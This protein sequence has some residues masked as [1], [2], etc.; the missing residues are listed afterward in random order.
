MT[1]LG[2]LLILNLPQ[3]LT[4]QTPVRWAFEN[5]R[6]SLGAAADTS[7]LRA[8]LENVQRRRAASGEAL[9]PALRAGLIGLRLG[10]LGADPGY[11]DALSRF[12]RAAKAEPGRPEPWFGL[13]LAEAGRSEWEMKNPLALGSRVGLGALERSV[14]N[15]A[16][17]VRVDPRFVPAS[18]ALAQVALA[19]MDTARLTVARDA[20]RRAEASLSPA[21]LDLILSWG[22]VERAAGSLDSA[23]VAF[24]RYISSGG[25]PGLGLLE[26]A[27][28]R[29]ALGRADGEGPYY[30]GAAFDD[31]EGIA[32]YRADLA[33]L[34][35]NAA[36]DEFDGLSGQARSAY[37]RRFWT[38][39]DQL[40][41]R[42]KGERLRE[43]YRR[44]Q[45]ARTHFPLT[46]SRRFYGRRDAYRSGND[47]IDDR[48]IIYI[49]HGDPDR[50]LRPFVFGAMPNESWYYVRPEGDLLLHFSGGYDGNGGGDLYDYRLV[51]SVMD[52]H[53]AAEAPPDQLL[54]SRASLSPVYNRMLTWG[55]YGSAD[56][57]AEERRLG[58]R[59]IIVSTTTDSYQLRFLRRLAA[60]ADLVSVGRSASGSLTHFVFG[61]ASP[62]TSAREVA[63]GVEYPV[64]IRVVALDRSDR[65][66]GRLDTTFVIHRRKPLGKHD[67]LIG[68]A[69]LTLPPG[70][71]IYRAAVQQGDSGGVVLPRDTVQVAPTD[72]LPLSLSDIALGSSDAAVP[73]ITEASDTVLLAPSGLFRKGRAV[74]I[75]YEVRGATAGSLYRH[76]ITVLKQ[77]RREAAAKRRPLVSLSFDE[78]ATG[79][80]VRSRRTVRL[81]RLKAGRYL[82]EVKVSAP[83]G[84]IVLR[85]RSLRLINP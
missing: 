17:A 37:L 25:K 3:Q 60:V 30:E 43:H 32:E 73:W 34:V 79:Q 56:A 6:D 29:F 57:G 15:Y 31:T 7:L 53:G 85:R 49:R 44:L 83:G 77:E 84:E 11:R 69:E 14:A 55:Q 22:R 65:A 72:G 41:L 23:E 63:E 38:D 16:R 2:L 51:Q 64:R 61:I 68:R 13:G 52:L 9:S 47:E 58:M 80:V 46:I 8:S 82:V 21:P 33:L 48:G 1:I 66:V 5:V 10:Q 70:R 27:R 67:Y 39:R 35:R 28:T 62:A 36:L 75:Y 12:R 42:G 54:L 45:F 26:L 81:E 19:L 76:E 78:E 50:R 20:L 24:V 4:V 74:E 71:W 18:L 59:S 40:E